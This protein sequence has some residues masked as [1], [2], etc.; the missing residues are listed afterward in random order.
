V[1]QDTKDMVF[2]YESA[3]DPLF[4][5]MNVG[6]YDLSTNGT[7]KRLGLANAAWTDRVGD[8]KGKFAPAK[9]FVPIGA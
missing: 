2:F 9:P 1:Y 5:W 3:V 6:D 7:T 8:M 4:F